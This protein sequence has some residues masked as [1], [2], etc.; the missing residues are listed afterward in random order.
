MR[1]LYPGRFILIESVTTSFKKMRLLQYFFQSL[2]FLLIYFKLEIKYLFDWITNM[3]LILGH[4]SLLLRALV[5]NI[6][7]GASI[8]APKIIQRTQIAGLWFESN[9]RHICLVAKQQLH[10][11]VAFWMSIPRLYSILFSIKDRITAK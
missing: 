1:I 8:F 9:G 5:I 10:L 6:I 3:V 2:S 11:V 4:F 7:D